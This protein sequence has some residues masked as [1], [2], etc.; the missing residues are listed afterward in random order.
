MRVG[1]EVRDLMGPFVGC[2][3]WDRLPGAEPLLRPGFD[4]ARE[5]GEVVEFT[6]FY[7]GRVRR[8]R[9]VPSDDKLAVEVEHSTELDVT[10]LESL[11]RSLSLIEAELAARAHERRGPRAPASLQALP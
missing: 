9:A 10:T 2:V 3:L 7:A 5:S 11:A 4:R 8:Y 6:V 1:P